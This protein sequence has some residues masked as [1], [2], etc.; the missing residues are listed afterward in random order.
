M[1]VYS[2]DG[3][4]Y[5]RLNTPDNNFPAEYK[6]F[7]SDLEEFKSFFIN[8]VNS[9]KSVSFVHFGD[10]DYYFLKKIPIGSAS[11]GKRALSKQYN[12]FDI[13]PYKE[14]WL[15]AD[16]HFVEY[17]EKGN[18]DKLNELY[19]NQKTMATEFLYGLLMNKWFLQNFKGKVG[20]IG[21]GNKL[22]IIKELMKRTE[23][24]E[25]LGVDKFND[26]I[27]IPQ[28]YACDNLD[29]TINMV[30]IQL[31][32]ADN[33]TQIYLYG[34]GHVKSGLIH[35]LPKI[36]KAI[37]V[38]IGAGI[39][40]LAG[41]IDPERPYASGWVNYRL[42]NYDYSDIDLLNYNIRTDMNLKIV[43]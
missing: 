19:P 42:K 12:N 36:K 4:E 11:P 13:I 40:A 31:E 17:L 35:H 27:K 20:L 41:I 29:N 9:N 16:Y 30:K 26:Y 1:N 37:Y 33:N 39:D 43:D 34:V 5:N 3:A 15:K 10:G 2:I 18:R 21:A 22:D 24:Q 14:G 32:Q 28:K 25:Y 7:K 8:L 38:D 23:Y 6:T